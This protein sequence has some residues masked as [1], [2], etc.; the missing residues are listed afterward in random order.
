MTNQADCIHEA[1]ALQAAEAELRDL[2]EVADQ[3][4]SVE[5]LA[6]IL[7]EIV[8]KLRPRGRQ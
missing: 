6:Q 4:D 8:A 3:W 1:H 5:D 7:E 2:L